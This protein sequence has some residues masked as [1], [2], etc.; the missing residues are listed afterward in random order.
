MRGTRPWL[1]LATLAVGVVAGFL[2]GG[3]GPRFELA[4]R[5]AEVASLTEELETAER[6]SGWRSPVPGLDRILQAPDEGRALPVAPEVP[7]QSGSE[8]DRGMPMADGG[9]P[10]AGRPGW[11]SR[12][13]E[14]S[15]DDRVD[16]FRRAASVQQVRRVQSRAALQQQADLSDEEMEVVDAALATMNEELLGYGEEILM[17]AM[18]DE[19]PAARDLLGITHDVTGILQ[20]AQLDVEAVLGP[21]RAAAVDPSALEI[22]NHVDLGQLEPAARAALAR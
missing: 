13:G 5:E 11:R 6:S 12:W 3:V 15:G 2:L 20:R 19:P 4:E 22:W 21:E 1:A 9:V 10:D 14:R 17:L 16:G 8:P 7:E 18:G